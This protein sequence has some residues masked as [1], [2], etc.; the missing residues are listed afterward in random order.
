MGRRLRLAALPSIA[1]RI[2]AVQ[3]LPPRDRLQALRGLP[4]CERQAVWNGLRVE[5]RLAVVK[6]LAAPPEACGGD[7]PVAPGR[8]RLIAFEAKRMEVTTAGNLREVSDG[9]AARVTDVFDVMEARRPK[10]A[11]RSGPL[12][13]A[14]QVATARDYR[15]LDERLNASGVRGMSL[16]TMRSGSGG[17]VDGFL[18]AVMDDAARLR[19]MRRR[20]GDGVALSVRRVRPSRRGGDSRIGIRDRYLVDMVCLRQC[21]I[22]EVLRG[23]GWSEDANNRKALVAA[24]GAALDRVGKIG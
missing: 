3:A 23:C 6:A 18:A 19:A 5:D 10:A 13:T 24:L 14:S 16:E 22:V 15:A 7:L 2:A 17:G 4:E 8:G 9:W 21:T 12:F 11:R 20:I 1:D